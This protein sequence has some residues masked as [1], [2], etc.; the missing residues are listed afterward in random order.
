MRQNSG[1]TRLRFCPNTVARLEPAH[2]RSRRLQADGEGHLALDAVH[3]EVVEQ[4]GQVRVGLVVEDEEAGVHRMRHA[5][6]GDVDGVRVAAEARRRLEERHG[7]ALRQ[8]PGGGKAGDARAD[9]G[10]ALAVGVHHLFSPL[11]P[12]ISA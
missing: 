9:D 3:P 11:L 8:Q 6:E 12:L 10:D 7:V 2:S 5:V 4:G 1:R